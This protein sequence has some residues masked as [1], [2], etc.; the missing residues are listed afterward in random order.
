[1]AAASL[2]G[3]SRT[4]PEELRPIR[5]WANFGLGVAPASQEPDIPDR[6]G[7]RHLLVLTVAACAGAVGALLAPALFNHFPLLMVDSWRYMDKAAGAPYWI[8]S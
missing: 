1:M 8:S 5:L 3:A 2:P 7:S 4:W 6:I